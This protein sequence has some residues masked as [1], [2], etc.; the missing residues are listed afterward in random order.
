VLYS[1]CSQLNC[2][3]GEYAL[4]NLVYAD[5]KLYGTTWL[6]GGTG[7]YE[8]T[9]CGTVFSVDPT[10]GAEQ[11]LYSFCTRQNCADGA[12]PYAGL[13][14]R[15]GVLYGTTSA[16]GGFG[17]SICSLGGCGTVFSLDLSTGIEK[18]LYSFCHKPDCRDGA[19]PFSG[20]VDVNGILYGTTG[21]GGTGGGIVFA[22]DEP[23]IGER[24]VYNFCSQ[25][26]CA[27]GKDPNTLVNVN[28]ELYGTTNSGGAYCQSNGGCGTVFVL[29]KTR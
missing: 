5:G 8:N 11:V 12:V 4:S 6:G 10:T 9:G 19:N 14:A 3:D 18:V 23:Y 17:T 20:L 24:V 26:N 29:R 7:C 25:Q 1:F 28:G 15:R 22:L 16:G 13:V 2:A 21:D 27:D